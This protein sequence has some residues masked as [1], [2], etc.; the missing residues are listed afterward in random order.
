[1]VCRKETLKSEQ[2]DDDYGQENCNKHN[3]KMHFGT[4]VHKCIKIKKIKV[5]IFL[6]VIKI[7]N[8]HNL[9]TAPS[10]IIFYLF[11]FPSSTLII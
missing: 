5:E 11:F 2:N 9:Q 4:K 10:Y 3:T 1:M 6:K 8:L 7:L